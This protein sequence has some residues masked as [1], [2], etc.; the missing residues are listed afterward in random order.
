MPRT[1]RQVLPDVPLHVV[2][3]G[4][5]RQPC[6]FCERDYRTYLR[7][8]ALFASQFDCAIHAY[9]LMTNHVHLL[10]TPARRDSCAQFMKRLGQQYVQGVNKRL[11]RSGTLWEGRFHSCIVQS[12]DHVLLCYRYIDLNPLRAGMVD[13]PEFYPWSSYS[14]N[15]RSEPEPTLTRHAAY[16]SLGESPA[17]RA[18]AYRAL[19][20]CDL[21]P[22]AFD[23]IRHATQ[24][25]ALL[26]FPRRKRGRPPSL[27]EKNG[28]C[29]H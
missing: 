12:P 6:F 25:G 20:A 27:N 15:V 14:A 22:T 1:P 19:A 2:Q 3:R 10:L 4:I 26:G 24:V 7:Y 5:N 8:L 13:S 11:G 29:P 21:P 23:T 28:V 18:A 17:D 9:C 16:E